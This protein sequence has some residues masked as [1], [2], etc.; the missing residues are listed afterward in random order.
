VHG[1]E[2]KCNHSD[3]ILATNESSIQAPP[4][5]EY[6]GNGG[7]VFSGTN[8]FGAASPDGGR[9]TSLS[10]TSG[11]TARKLARSNTMATSLAPKCFLENGQL[12]IA[13]STDTASIGNT[14]GFQMHGPD[15][16]LTEDSDDDQT[17]ERKFS[18]DFGR[19]D[20]AG[21]QRSRERPVSG[22]RG[23][24][25][26]SALN[27]SVLSADT[28]GGGRATGLSNYT[29]ASA[30]NSETQS[31]AKSAAAKSLHARLKSGHL[32][33]R[34]LFDDL[35]AFDTRTHT[36]RKIDTA[37]NALRTSTTAVTTSASTGG[38]GDINATGH[39]GMSNAF[40]KPRARRGHTLLSFMVIVPEGDDAGGVTSLGDGGRPGSALEIMRG[41][42]QDVTAAT[43][44]DYGGANT[45]R[46]ESGQR[47]PEMEKSPS[48][49]VAPRLILY[50]GQGFHQGRGD[51]T[52]GDLWE[53][54]DA[55]PGR[56]VWRC[57]HSDASMIEEPAS[58]S[59]GGSRFGYGMQRPETKVFEA[60]YMPPFDRQGGS[61][62]GGSNNA[63]GESHGRGSNSPNKSN[64]GD[65]SPR[66][67][68]GT[69]EGKS[70]FRIV[71]PP[72]ASHASCVIA[73]GLYVFGGIY[74]K[75]LLNDLWRLDL[76]TY[77]WT[78]IG[79]LPHHTQLQDQYH[80]MLEQIQMQQLQVQRS[81]KH[82]SY[83]LTDDGNATNRTART[84]TPATSR[85]ESG[86]L[87]G[88]TNTLLPG[89]ATG[90][91]PLQLPS[92]SVYDGAS[93]VTATGSKI[94]NLT[95][96]SFSSSVWPAPGYGG[97]LVPDPDPTYATRRYVHANVVYTVYCRMQCL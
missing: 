32:L 66:V 1:G 10:M 46:D 49:T 67:M 18:R 52:L 69:G 8:K 51:V 53:V 58:K 44:R 39:D 2:G 82:V 11:T 94:S 43:G 6:A 34:E 35:Y 16:L 88:R 84:A 68:T 22:G 55:R 85:E 9:S 95:Y 23:G 74:D 21:S 56:E 15:A 81:G 41:V 80:A 12:D 54:T 91:L 28:R 62:I 37:A 31:Q 50:G 33:S 77:T 38:G 24:R 78:K 83:A 40:A 20:T 97:S 96:A 71:P 4:G 70:K 75:C 5:D 73:N 25:A 89:Q 92:R 17:A 90:G 79:P 93:E 3:T 19:P 65:S 14:H 45:A 30:T 57:I 86:T 13:V 27:D 59:N 29:H 64:G 7:S 42:Q 72:R 36:W 87:L 63:T 26:A 76:V 61:S 60:E 48:L 47:T